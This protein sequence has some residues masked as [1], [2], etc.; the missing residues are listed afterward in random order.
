MTG[1]KTIFEQRW[2]YTIVYLPASAF[3]YKTLFGTLLVSDFVYQGLGWCEMALS[4]IVVLGIRPLI[5]QL[6]TCVLHIDVQMA[7]ERSQLGLKNM[8][9]ILI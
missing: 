7:N 9:A 8:R 6:Y 3:M 1:H 5:L 4:G 2:A